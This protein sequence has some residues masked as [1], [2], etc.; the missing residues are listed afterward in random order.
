[1]GMRR[2]IF[3]TLLNVEFYWISVILCLPWEASEWRI[4]AIGTVLISSY[5]EILGIDRLPPVVS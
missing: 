5:E 1:L 2:R 3:L 4:R